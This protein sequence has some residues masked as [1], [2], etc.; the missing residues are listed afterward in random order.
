MIKVAIYG[1]VRFVLTI[2]HPPVWGGVLILIT[3]TISA[4]LGVIYTL[5]EHDIKRLLA[6]CS[7]ENIGIILLGVGLYVIFTNYNLTDLATLCI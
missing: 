2:A 4:L 7:I 1:I 6:Y 3:G 5:K